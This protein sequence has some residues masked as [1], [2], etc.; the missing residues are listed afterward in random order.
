MAD[1]FVTRWSLPVAAL[2]TA[3]CSC[4]NPYCGGATGLLSP[5]TLSE[6][7]PAGPRFAAAQATQGSVRA[8]GQ[9][10]NPY[11]P[12]FGDALAREVYRASSGSGFRVEVRDVLVGP[13]RKASRIHLAGPAVVEVRSGAGRFTMDSTPTERKTGATFAL[14]EGQTLDIENPGVVPITLRVQIIVAE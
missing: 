3:G 10:A 8:E 12:A 4:F 9:P 2:L 14:P 5:V 7:E 13:G 1:T 11:A 6:V